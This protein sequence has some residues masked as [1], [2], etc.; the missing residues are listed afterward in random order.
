MRSPN[1]PL[2]VKEIFQIIKRIN[3]EQKTTL[4]L[5]EQN[6]NIALQIAH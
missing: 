4:M 3:Q 2:L 5:V 1:A 6:A